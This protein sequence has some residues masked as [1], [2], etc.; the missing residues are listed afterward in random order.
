MSSSSAE[1]EL[2][3]VHVDEKQHHHLID[4]ST[5]RSTDNDKKSQ[6]DSNTI[7]GH[8]NYC[9]GTMDNHTA[10]LILQFLECSDLLTISLVSKRWKDWADNESLWQDAF[11]PNRTPGMVG[12]FRDQTRNYFYTSR[13]GNQQLQ[14]TIQKYRDQFGLEKKEIATICPACTYIN[15]FTF[16]TRG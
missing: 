7:V 15:K 2:I 3:N 10:C 13:D 8:G 14:R 6:F 9:F 1:A 5:P 4:K 12:L 11:S 16:I